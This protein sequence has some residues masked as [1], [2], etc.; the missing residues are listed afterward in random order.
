[1]RSKIAMVIIG[2]GCFVIGALFV[3]RQ[4]SNAPVPVTQ[5]SLTSTQPSAQRDLP[6]PPATNIT[7]PPA[8]PEQ[9]NV[10]GI[11]NAAG[12]TGSLQTNPVDA[13][14]ASQETY[15]RARISELEDLAMD[16]S[17]SS[18]DVILSELR[19]SDP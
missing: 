19:N 15:V 8:A 14:K 9:P 16:N 10:A 13:A 5:S 17:S 2:S 1:M 18:L 11:S 4:K 7:Q 6:A 12:I 3:I